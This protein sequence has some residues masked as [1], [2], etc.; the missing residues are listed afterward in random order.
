MRH[1]P[2]L[3]AAII[4]AWLVAGCAMR[5]TAP[6]TSAVYEPTG[7]ALGA[8]AKDT[9]YVA[10]LAA[11]APQPD[12]SIKVYAPGGSSPILTQPAVEPTN[13]RSIAFDREGNLYVANY[14]DYV[15][16]YAPKLP[17]AFLTI[18]KG[19]NAP[20]S[21]TIDSTGDLY[22]GNSGDHS[23]SVFAPHSATPAY[24]IA[25]KTGYPAALAVDDS[26][27]LYVA[28]EDSNAVT[29]FAFGQT[30]PLRNIVTGDGP[31][32]LL[33]DGSDNLYVA[34]EKASPQG[35]VTV[36]APGS[37]T[38]MRTITEGI[39]DPLELCLDNAKNIYVL[40][41]GGAAYTAPT[42]TV[43]AAGSTKLLR[44]IDLT[45]KTLYYAMGLDSSANVYV[46]E[47]SGAQGAVRVYEAGGSTLLRSITKGIFDPVAIGFGAR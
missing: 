12:G 37:A 42:V 16:V 44:T 45:P 17:G 10:N 6:P 13:K 28:N 7:N 46:A 25:K 23:I 11:K 5:G 33:L 35:S 27:N 9:L 1:I 2:K 8:T 14:G 18:T 15:T 26:R 40:N 31:D 19:L 30:T 41:R 47:D 36:F 32:D 39:N 4:A 34:N 21:L 22:V 38:P 20:I 3:P 24:T 43:Y 29:E